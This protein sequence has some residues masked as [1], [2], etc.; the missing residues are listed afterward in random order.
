MQVI[1]EIV[2]LLQIA[3]FLILLIFLATVIINE[4][5]QLAARVHHESKL[6]FNKTKLIKQYLLE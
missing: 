4:R 3:Y 5:A 2:N 6:L 1:A